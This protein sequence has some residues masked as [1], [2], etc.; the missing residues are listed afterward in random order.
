MSSLFNALRKTSDLVV[1]QPNATRPLL[2]CTMAIDFDSAKPNYIKTLLNFK[3]V[4][5]IGH[6]QKYKDGIIKTIKSVANVSKFYC[7]TESFC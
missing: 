2:P 5:L 6:F 4:V 3:K 7:I 1:L